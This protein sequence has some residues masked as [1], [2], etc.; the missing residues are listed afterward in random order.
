MQVHGGSLAGQLVVDFTQIAAGPICTMMLADRGADVVKIESPQGDLGRS[1]GPPFINGHGTI[2]MSLNRNKRS[3]V[4]DLKRSRDLEV[5]RRLVARAD[6][7][8]ESFRPGVMARF[9]LDYEA[10]SAINPQLVYCSIS[11]YGQHGPHSA[12][13]GVDGIVQATSGLM[14][15]TGSADG[16]PAK[17]QSPI[18]DMTTGFLA[19][20]A[21]LDAVMARDSGAS[22]A[23]LDVSMYAAGIQLQQM[24]L[25]SYLASG[26]VPGACGSA[27]PYSAPNEAFPTRDGWVMI[28]AYQPRR[29]ERLC[30]ILDIPAMATDSRFSSSDLRVTNRAAMVDAI[31]ARTRVWETAALLSALEAGDIICGQVNTYADVAASPAFG[32]MTATFQHPEAGEVRVIA[33]LDTGWREA[34]RAGPMRPAPLL[35]QHTREIVDLVS[36]SD[37]DP[38]KE[39]A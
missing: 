8:V 32:D 20:T 7:L 17:V 28:A 30:Q 31:S 16:V 18:V 14:S 26:E 10:M 25:A 39:G 5:A 33:P 4:L 29:W 3:A 27:A 1:L 22:G 6:I 21:I 36:G 15:I 13:P 24:G 19:L 2:F 9:G 38:L 12:K 35:G 11:A 37:V 23:F 34:Y